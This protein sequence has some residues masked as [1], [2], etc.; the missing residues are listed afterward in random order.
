MG[1]EE[2]DAKA[3]REKEEG[4]GSV[5]VLLLLEEA[6]ARQEGGVPVRIE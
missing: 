4:V 1:R 6:E 2:E 3:D 5:V